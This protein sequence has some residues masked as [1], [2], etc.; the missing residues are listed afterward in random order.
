[1]QEFIVDIN[2]KVQEYLKLYSG[3]AQVVHV[4]S[5]CGRRLQFPANSL[6]NFVDN[7]GV[8]GTFILVVDDN[9]K[10]QEIRRL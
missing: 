4:W 8:R 5:R 6:R 3:R 9:L 2:I 7:S 1:M 10:L